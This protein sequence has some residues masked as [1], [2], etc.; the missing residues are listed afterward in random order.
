MATG[1]LYRAIPYS[2]VRRAEAVVLKG[3]VTCRLDVDA[4]RLQ[5]PSSALFHSAPDAGVLAVFGGDKATQAIAPYLQEHSGSR[6]R[7]LTQEDQLECRSTNQNRQRYSPTGNSQSCKRTR[8]SLPGEANDKPLDTVDTTSSL[9]GGDNELFQLASNEPILTF[10]LPGFFTTMYLG[11]KGRARRDNAEETMSWH[12]GGPVLTAYGPDLP[13]VGHTKLN[14]KPPHTQGGFAQA[15]YCAY[16]DDS[17][18]CLYRA[19]LEVNPKLVK[20]FGYI[21][22]L[23][24]VGTAIS[25]PTSSVKDTSPKPAPSTPV[26]NGAVNISILGARGGKLSKGTMQ[27]ST[28]LYSGAWVAATCFAVVCWASALQKDNGPEQGGGAFAVQ[29]ERHAVADGAA[30]GNEDLARDFGADTALVLT[31]TD[32]S[33][34]TGGRG[35]HAVLIR[36][37][38][39]PPITHHRGGMMPRPCL[40]FG[41]DFH[42]IRAQA[43]APPPRLEKIEQ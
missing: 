24:K 32:G 21:S 40:D 17:S 35:E 4:C 28:G 13:L 41:Q 3:E 6:D 30:G 15:L 38:L 18:C 31:L 16:V 14:R 5:E 43:P 7:N 10:N 34:C 26:L 1:A 22:L 2:R 25:E 33:H 27:A 8:V 37:S 19:S 23:I 42:G 11:G 9:I 20:A 29:P 12:S 39:G 36:V